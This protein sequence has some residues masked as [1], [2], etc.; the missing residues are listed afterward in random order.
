MIP[1]EG[2]ANLPALFDAFEAGGYD[3]WYDLEI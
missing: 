2:C 1:G 3:G